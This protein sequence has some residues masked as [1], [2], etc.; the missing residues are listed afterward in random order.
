MGVLTPR[1]KEFDE[2]MRGRQG[3]GVVQTTA[4]PLSQML[5]E[6]PFSECVVI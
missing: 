5:E 1:L 6:I 4:V 2:D 3:H